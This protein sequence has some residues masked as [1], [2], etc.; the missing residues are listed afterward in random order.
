[1]KFGSNISGTKTEL[2]C[3]SVLFLRSRVFGQA[4][5]IFLVCALERETNPVD[6]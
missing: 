1:M 5:M 2:E 3:Q 6:Q 4:I